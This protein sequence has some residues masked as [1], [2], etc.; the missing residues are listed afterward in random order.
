[1]ENSNDNINTPVTVEPEV[2]KN[3]PSTKRRTKTIL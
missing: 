1:M 3:I 2:K